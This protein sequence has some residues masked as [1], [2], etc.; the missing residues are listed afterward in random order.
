MNQRK[1]KAVKTALSEDSGRGKTWYETY[2]NRC[3]AAGRTPFGLKR[4]KRMSKGMRIKDVL[5]GKLI[6]LIEDKTWA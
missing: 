4:I 1:V 5:N 2:V 6:E 3:V